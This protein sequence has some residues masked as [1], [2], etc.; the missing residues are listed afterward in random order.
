[1][2]FIEIIVWLTIF[3]IFAGV[4]LVLDYWGGLVRS[5]DTYTRDELLN[6]MDILL[7][8]VERLTG[9]RGDPG[10]AYIMFGAGILIAWVLTL[11]GGLLSPNVM[12]HAPDHAENQVPNYFFQSILFLVILHVV[13]PSLRDT[14]LDQ[15]GPDG[16]PARLASAETPFFFGLAVALG[17]INLT[18]WGVYHE[19]TFLFA[20]INAGLCFIYGGYRLHLAA[21]ENDDEFYDD[22]GGGYGAA[23]SY[24]DNYDEGP[25]DVGDF[26]GGGMEPQDIELD[27]GAGAD[28]SDLRERGDDPY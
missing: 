1:M 28:D 7:R 12:P 19:M 9:R 8:Q 18:T 25:G 26:D 21:Q 13:W 16:F 17:A 27:T 10:P 4:I 5:K 2:I 6:F 14:A 20:S 15:G 23:E 11:F 24:D 3:A 22:Y